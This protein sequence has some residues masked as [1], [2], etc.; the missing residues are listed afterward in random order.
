M[1]KREAL[2]ILMEKYSGQ[3]IKLLDYSK[4]AIDKTALIKVKLKEISA[5]KSGY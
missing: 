3:D 4:S 5:K 1:K 2:D